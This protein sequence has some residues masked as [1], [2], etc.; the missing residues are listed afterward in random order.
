MKMT[1]A[2][3]LAKKGIKPVSAVNPT[4]IVQPTVEKKET[5]STSIILDE[6]QKTA[7]QLAAAGKSFCIIG[8]AGTGKTTTER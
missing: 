4:I 7:V 1:L 5:F 3:L 8:K 6:D 2:E